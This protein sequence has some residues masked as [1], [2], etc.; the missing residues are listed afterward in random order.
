[1]NLDINAGAP[2]IVDD[3]HRHWSTGYNQSSK[4]IRMKGD[5]K[6]DVDKGIA[7]VQKGVRSGVK[8]VQKDVR[9]GVKEV[10]KGARK[11]GDAVD[12]EVKKVQTKAKS[13]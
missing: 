8:E 13:K 5:M 4:V 3:A 2:N 12:K 11:V 1:L 6:K 7:D 9:A 10:Q